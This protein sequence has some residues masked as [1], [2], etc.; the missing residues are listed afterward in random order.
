MGGALGG[1]SHN[2]LSS[3]ILLEIDAT[4]VAVLE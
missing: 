4:G 1:V 3:V 2:Y